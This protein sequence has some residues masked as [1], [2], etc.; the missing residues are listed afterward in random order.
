MMVWYTNKAD[1]A[2]IIL[3]PPPTIPTSKDTAAPK[4]LNLVPYLHKSIPTSIPSPVIPVA[5]SPIQF[6]AQCQL[7]RETFPPFPT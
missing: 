5:H 4:T 7:L 2:F 1:C 3:H 6:S